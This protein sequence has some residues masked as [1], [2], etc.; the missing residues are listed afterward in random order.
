[1]TRPISLR[2]NVSWTLFGNVVYAVCL[3]GMM[4]LLAKK[5]D[6]LLVGRYA[7]GSLI[8]GPVIMFTNLE[9]R[10]VQATDAR[11]AYSFADYLGLRTLMVAL[12]MVIILVIAVAGYDAQQ[13]IVVLAFGAVRCVESI[14]DIFHGFAQKHDR[15]DLVSMSFMLKGT[16]GLVFF[17]G[18]FLVFHSLPAGLVGLTLGWALVVRFF[19]VPRNRR[20]MYAG[21]DGLDAA[22]APLRPRWDK[23]TMAALVRL[24]WPLGL[25]MLL[26]Q[27]RNTIPRA[28]LESLFG[29]QDLGIFSALAYVMIAGNTLIVA[30]SQSSIARLSQCYAGGRL[31]DFHRLIRRLVGFGILLGA[32]GVLVAALAGPWILEILYTREYAARPDVFVHLMVAGAVL[33]VG[34]LLGAA[35]TAMRAFRA[36]LVVNLVNILIMAGLSVWLIPHFGMLGAAW[37]MLG[38]AAWITAGQWI[39]IRRGKTGSGDRPVPGSDPQG[40]LS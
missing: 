12:A 17:A 25:G 35:T 16:V 26:V 14:G 9:L 36:K 10:S 31:D 38:S 6:P 20:L 7:I 3:W 32:G 27:M 34:S 8:V 37:T 4:A 28:Y 39:I 13:V 30:V 23:A 5:G 22:P 24:T 33:N 29:E 1:M 15:M 40:A 2:R 19:D 11:D 21:A 18:G